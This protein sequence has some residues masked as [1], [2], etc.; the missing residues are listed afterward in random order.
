ML[1]TNTTGEEIADTFTSNIKGKGLLITGAEICRIIA[2]NEPKLIIMAGRKPQAIEETMFKIKNEVPNTPLRP[3]II[4]LGSIESVENAAKEVNEYKEYV[5]VSIN[6]A[7][8]MAI[9][10]RKTENG[11]DA[12]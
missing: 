4:D 8:I 3:L 6:N 5:N 9:P 12:H 7:A 10:Y 2:D 11:F 1:F